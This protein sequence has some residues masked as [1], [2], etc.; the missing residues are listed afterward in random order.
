MERSL[1]E[2][3]KVNNRTFRLLA[4][5][6][7]DRDSSTFTHFH[8]IS[9]RF[10]LPAL[11]AEF[12]YK[13]LPED[14]DLIFYS[15]RQ[16]FLHTFDY[17][18]KTTIMLNGV[19]HY[20]SCSVQ[21]IVNS[22]FKNQLKDALRGRLCEAYAD[23]FLASL[24]ETFTLKGSART[25]EMDKL[26]DNDVDSFDGTINFLDDLT[27]RLSNLTEQ[28]LSEIVRVINGNKLNTTSSP[29]VFNLLRTEPTQQ[30]SLNI[31]KIT[32]GSVTHMI[33]ERV[34]FFSMDDYQKL[35]SG[36]YYIP[37]CEVVYIT[38]TLT[39]RQFLSFTAQNAFYTFYI[40]EDNIDSYKLIAGIRSDSYKWFSQKKDASK[41]PL[42][43]EILNKD[44]FVGTE[45]V[46]SKTVILNTLLNA[47]D[48]VFEINKRSSDTLK[49]NSRRIEIYGIFCPDALET[50]VNETKCTF[51][52]RRVIKFNDFLFYYVSCFVLRDFKMTVITLIPQLGNRLCREKK[53]SCNL[54]ELS[55]CNHACLNV[56]YHTMFWFY[57]EVPDELFDDALAVARQNFTNIM[58]DAILRVA[59]ATQDIK[60]GDTPNFAA[61]K[62]Q[63]SSPLVSA[64]SVRT[65][66]KISKVGEIDKDYEMSTINEAILS[67]TPY[68]AGT[69]STLN[70]IDI[71]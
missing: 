25:D 63:S 22:Y 5:E 29:N 31:K 70:A 41:L 8:S 36:K 33:D 45:I 52:I 1:L 51:Y 16:T 20:T 43:Y 40:L 21:H 6:T 42:Q 38:I 69:N 15:I 39:K 14:V 37:R 65:L 9:D 50:F 56:I 23:V 28:Q 61:L 12:A 4:L 68:C 57:S 2:T 66:E 55:W 64:L 59:A 49:T 53:N 11:V 60:R 47:D 3:Y 18:I 13:N 35:E 67:N 10:S 71:I 58:A 17:G 62:T 7:L 44:P 19:A 26:Y 48:F 54:C 30:S 34:R 24:R 27:S 32:T 46:S